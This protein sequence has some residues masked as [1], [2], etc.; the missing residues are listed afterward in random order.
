M[1]TAHTI[2]L[3]AV[4]AET[5]GLIVGGPDSDNGQLNPFGLSDD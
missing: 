2:E 3:G 1:K 4:S 5:R